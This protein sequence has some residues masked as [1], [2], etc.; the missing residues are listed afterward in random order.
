MAVQRAVAARE[1]EIP[2]ARR[3]RYRVGINVGDIV[4]DGDDIYGDGVNIAAR[5]E[6]IAEPGGI[7][8]SATVHDHLKG[9]VDAVFEDLGDQ[10]VK[11][12]TRPIKAWRWRAEGAEA[13]FAS[14]DAAAPPPLPDIPSIA[15]LPFDNMSG[16][17]EQVYFSDGLTEDLITALS[18][19]VDLMV[20][21]RNS[22]FAF[23]GGNVDVQL[24]GKQLGARYVLEGS[25]RKSGNQV[26]I[27]AQL[28]EADTRKHIWAERFDGS[29]ENVFELQDAITAQITGQ[30]LPKLEHA[31]T[32]RA[33]RLKPDE[34]SA[35][36]LYLRAI[37]H[38]YANSSEDSFSALNLLKQALEISPDYPPALALSGICRSR[39][40]SMSWDKSNEP[41]HMSAGVAAAKRAVEL[42]PEDATVLSMSGLAIGRLSGDL[43]RGIDLLERA[44]TLNPNSCRAHGFAGLLKTHIGDA[45]EAIECLKLAIRLNPIDPRN[46]NI[47]AN[48]S[49]AYNQMKNYDD[50][51]RHA[52]AALQLNP[53]YDHSHREY[54]ESCIGLG[55][56]EDARTGARALLS[57]FPEFSLAALRDRWKRQLRPIT[58]G[59]LDHLEA[60]RKA[61][62]PD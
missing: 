15:V 62:L 12:I 50:G 19:S 56:L 45:G 57:Q 27:N 60:L 31:E 24:V 36:D 53:R 38:Y 1:A 20:I 29:L 22:S 7:T 49:N 5:L 16:D 13:A 33:G 28:I 14:P 46:F 17:P 48:L 47:H 8:I 9:K 32:E 10:Q 4:I 58:Q 26:R 61:G 59:R 40:L 42:A 41:E 43:Q 25:V 55:Q 2:D 18:K 3:I 34:V 21:A 11:N 39:M 51:K 23:R 37:H 35:Y 6:S 44:I 54:I 52:L 30:L